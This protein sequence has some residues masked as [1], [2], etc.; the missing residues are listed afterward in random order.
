[1]SIDLWFM[2]LNCEIGPEA[3]NFGLEAEKRYLGSSKGCGSSRLLRVRDC[4]AWVV[5]AVVVNPLAPELRE[6]PGPSRL[7]RGGAMKNEARIYRLNGVAHL[8]GNINQE[9]TRVISYVRRQQNMSLHEQI[10]PYLETMGM[11]HLARLNISAF[12]ERWHPETHTFHIPF[13]ECTITLQDLGLPIDGE[14]VSGRLTDFENLMDNGRPLSPPN[15]V[16]QMM[17]HFTWFHERFRVLPADASEETL[18][19]DKSVNR[20]HLCWLPYL[21]I[22]AGWTVPGCRVPATDAQFGV[23]LNEPAASPN[24]PWFTIGGTP[25]STFSVVP[26]HTSPARHGQRPT[27]MR[28]PARWGT[29][30]HLIGGFDIDDD[31]TIENSD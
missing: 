24:D 12:V 27:R 30:S 22:D 13:G 28:R 23:D 15:K 19:G 9:P 1:M 3:V 7:W 31:D 5:A 18:F 25:G 16:K 14:A 21:A 8:A 20:V 17:V 2:L 6:N 4:D 10:I 29:K 26:P 11:Y